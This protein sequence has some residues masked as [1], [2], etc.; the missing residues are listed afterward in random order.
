MHRNHFL[1][2]PLCGKKRPRPFARQY[3]LKR[4]TVDFENFDRPTRRS[5]IK[6]T[7]YKP[8]GVP[9]KRI[10]VGPVLLKIGPCAC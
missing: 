1:G 6:D 3:L 7:D 2:A 9:R 10:K 4:L 8:A 5:V